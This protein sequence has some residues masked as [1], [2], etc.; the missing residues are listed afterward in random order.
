MPLQQPLTNLPLL[1]PAAILPLQQPPP[2][3]PAV[4]PAPIPAGPQLQQPLP[5]VAT[6]PPKCAPEVPK[7]ILQVISEEDKPVEPERQ[8]VKVALLP[9]PPALSPAKLQQ[10]AARLKRPAGGGLQP[11]VDEGLWDTLKRLA[12]SP[13][14]SG[15]SWPLQIPTDK[16][17]KGTPPKP[18]T[19]QLISPDLV[20][21]R[22]P[23]QHTRK[24]QKKSLTELY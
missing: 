20:S 13:D 5:V 6:P 12:I 17:G 22:L 7:R 23:S 24:M 9:L 3:Q 18:G 11:E 8:R 2:L 1:Q 15:Q 14:Q 16:R 21:T 10:L 4:L 19:Y